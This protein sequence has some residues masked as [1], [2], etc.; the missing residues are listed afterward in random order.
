M[1]NATEEK[2]NKKIKRRKRGR[3][4]GKIICITLAALFGFVSVLGWALLIA[5]NS[6]EASVRVVPDYERIDLTDI[7]L[8]E[9]WSEEDYD[10]IYRQTGLTKLGA[11]EYRE[12]PERL[13]DFQN[14][15]FFEGYT[16]HI[17]AAPT[18]QHDQL[19]DPATNSAYTAPIVPL[20]MGDVLVTSSCHTFGWRNGHTAIVVDNTHGYTLESLALGMNSSFNRS[21][22]A[23]FQHAANFMVLRLKDTDEALRAEIANSAMELLLDVPYSVT[24]GILSGK[25]RCDGGTKKADMTHCSHLVWQAFKN[26]GIDLDSDGGGL[27]TSKDIARSPLLE[28]VQ[29]YGFDVDELW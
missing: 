23:W 14:A 29:V 12:T 19:W 8:K 21:G 18:T 11:D 6:I 26:F 5:D 20:Q 10:V 28:L 27:V 2:R 17:A 3:L 24:V 15:L 9:E 1:G 22:R 25:D 4:A 7:L 13:R 16:H